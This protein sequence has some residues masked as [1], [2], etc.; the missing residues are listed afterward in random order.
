MTRDL[1]KYSHTAS[2]QH[3]SVLSW[4]CIH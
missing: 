4:F 1:R 3:K 2:L